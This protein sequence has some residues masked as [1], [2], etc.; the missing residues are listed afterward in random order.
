MRQTRHS[1]QNLKRRRGVYFPRLRFWF[2][3][4][5]IGQQE[6]IGSCFPPSTLPRSVF[7]A[8]GVTAAKQR[9]QS[10]EA[11]PAARLDDGGTLATMAL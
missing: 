10:P 11:M 5:F 8:P 2:L 7:I 9:H 1:F 6:P 3:T 4:K